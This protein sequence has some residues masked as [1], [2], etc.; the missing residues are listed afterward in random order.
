MDNVRETCSDWKAC[1]RILVVAAALVVAGGCAGYDD[2]DDVIVDQCASVADD[3][4][5]TISFVDGC[6]VSV[7]VQ[8]VV[9]PRATPFIRWVSKP[10]NN[11]FGIF[12][13]PLMGPQ[14]IS[15]KKG[16]LRR[17]VSTKVPPVENQGDSGYTVDYKYTVAKMKTTGN[18][19]DPS[20]NVLDPKVIVAH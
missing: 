2:V 6:P 18:D 7:S 8:E 3:H 5:I 4:V 11:K 13:D 16:C 17:A 19:V 14:Y 20:C 9:V 15:N 1:G 12:F 10:E